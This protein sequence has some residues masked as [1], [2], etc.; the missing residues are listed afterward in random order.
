MR[1]QRYCFFLIYA[2]LLGVLIKKASAEHADAS[3]VSKLLQC[4]FHEL[5]SLERISH[6][7]VDSPV[8]HMKGSYSCSVIA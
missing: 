4:V 5:V 6:T 7:Q 2:N 1:L 3:I 8:E